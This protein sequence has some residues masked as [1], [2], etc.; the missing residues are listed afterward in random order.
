MAR[1]NE[2]HD[3][4]MES[5]TEALLQLMRSKPLV[6]ISVSELCEKAGVSRISYYRN[7][8]SMADILVRYLNSC[9]DK[10]W[11]EF[12]QK[13]EDEFYKE[14]WPSL[15][16]EYRNNAELI[17]LIY[18]NNV[19][20]ILMDHIFDCVT[21]DSSGEERDAFVRSALAGALFG[22]VSEWIRR[23]MGEP[24]EGFRLIEMVR[25]MENQ[26]VRV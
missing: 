10:W 1:K 13:P 23:G 20:Y 4:V 24:P 7:Y 15:L 22:L 26:G 2:A 8:S 17:R 14:F 9:T 19:R 11:E 18:D 6:E 5:M 16:N 3:M 25:L 21:K 12:S